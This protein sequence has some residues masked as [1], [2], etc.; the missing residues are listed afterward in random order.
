MMSEEV[1]TNDVG[2]IVT[3][4]TNDVGGIV[5]GGTNDVGGSGY[6]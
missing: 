6:E 2:G 1:G 4:G 5:T 3:G